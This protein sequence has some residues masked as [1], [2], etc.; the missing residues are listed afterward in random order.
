M[1]LQY[2]FRYKDYKGLNGEEA[3]TLFRLLQREDAVGWLQ[4][5]SHA[6]LEDFYSLVEAFKSLFCL[7]PE[8]VWLAE[9]EVWTQNQA[10]A[11]SV[12]KFVTRVRRSA[13]R[14][15]MTDASL[16]NAIIQGLRPPIR[17]AVL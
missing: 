12:D 6:E 17:M 8:L 16:N 9:S 11:E 10:A 14:A 13:R 5:L 7:S 1:W 4:T 3:A 15:N 2:F